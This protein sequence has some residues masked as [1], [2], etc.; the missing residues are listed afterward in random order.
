VVLYQ[1]GP[2]GVVVGDPAAGVVTWGVE[3]FVR[4]YSEA[5]LVFGP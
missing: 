3:F 1:V 5:L 2:G 4:V